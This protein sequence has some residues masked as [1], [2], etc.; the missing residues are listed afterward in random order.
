MDKVFGTHM[1]HQG[2]RGTSS[3]LEGL[4]KVKVDWISFV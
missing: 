1:G 3:T 2:G 4:R